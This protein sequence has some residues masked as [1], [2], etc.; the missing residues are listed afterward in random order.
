MT[1]KRITEQF[2]WLLP[3]RKRQ[4]VFCFY[5]KMALDRR[6]YAKTIEKNSLPF[7]LFSSSSPLYNK[8][9]G[10]DMKYQENKVFNLKLVSKKL[11]GLVINPGETFSFWKAVRYADR[12]VPYRDG[13]TVIN[14]E[15]TTTSGGGLC[16]MSN[17]LFDLFLHSPLQ[18]IERTGHRKKEFPDPGTSL[19]G[20]DAAVSEGWLDLKVENRENTAFQIRITFDDE[21]IYG[22]LRTDC[23]QDA[24]Y[25]LGNRN[26][27]YIKKEARIYQRAEL[28]RKIQYK[29]VCSREEKL[30]ENWCEITYAL[31]DD[32]V[33]EEEKQ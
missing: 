32:V 7:I 8:E 12:E 23:L 33:I 27:A 2:P 1:R 24:V 13:L 26:V 15:L 11:D 29:D 10:F 6:H 18:I 28:Y 25:E 4:R 9:T 20:C 14:G 22:F 30:Y 16:Q 21:K 5:T 17:L 19:A 3:L 31:P